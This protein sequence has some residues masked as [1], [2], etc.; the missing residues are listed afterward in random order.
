MIV[1]LPGKRALPNLGHRCR[2]GK[3]KTTHVVLQPEL[4]KQRY[5]YGTTATSEWS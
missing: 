1:F 5:V 4:P 2:Q 3:G